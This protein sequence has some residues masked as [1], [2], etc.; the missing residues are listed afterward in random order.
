MLLPNSRSPVAQWPVLLL[1]CQTSPHFPPPYNGPNHPRPQG[2]FA[3]LS[4]THAGLPVAVTV[5]CVLCLPASCLPPP[6][7]TVAVSESVTAPAPSSPVLSLHS[8]R[9]VAVAASASFGLG[10]STGADNLLLLLQGQSRARSLP[11]VDH[12][13]RRLGDVKAIP[14]SIT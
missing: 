13:V 5:A 4:R 3:L 6:L 9:R 10:S 2:G 12:R 7:D 11:R 8:P 14:R 1:Q